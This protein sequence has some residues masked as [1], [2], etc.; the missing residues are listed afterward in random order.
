VQLHSEDQVL[1]VTGLSNP[2]IAKELD[3]NTPRQSRIT[4]HFI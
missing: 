2:E 3:V 1:M 4:L